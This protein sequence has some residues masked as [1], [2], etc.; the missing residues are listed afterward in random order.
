MTNRF[1]FCLF[2]IAVFFAAE[3]IH[4]QKP[5]AATKAQDRESL[6]RATRTRNKLDTNKNGTFEKQENPKA[7][8]R[9]KHLDANN[10]EVL[11]VEE[12]QQ[13]RRKEQAATFDTGGEQKLNVVYKQT[14]EGDQKLDIYYPASKQ[15]SPYPVIIYTHGGGWAA[16]SK[17]GV[18]KTLFTPLFLKLLD[19]GFVVASVNYRLCKPHRSVRMRDC[20]IDSK[21]AV[22]YLA[23]NSDDLNLDP[24]RMF[25][26]GDSAGGQIAQMLLLTSPDTLPGDPTLADSSYN[27]VAGVSWYG[28]SSFEDMQLFNHDD[29][30]DF[31]DRF[32]K[33]ITGPA[34]EPSE[35]E[36]MALY[37][38]MSTVNYVTDESPPLLMIQGNKDTTI[39]VKHA[40][41]M[42]QKAE[43]VGAPVEIMIIE[44]SGHN[45]RKA[46]ADIEPS[47]DVIV[48]RTV[49]FF[50]D[51]QT[52]N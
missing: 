52:S 42:Q 29:R 32:G 30:P 36:K 17:E 5:D 11:T 51:H 35:D 13:E 45:W 21:D 1:S 10:D 49:Q 33:R 50:V 26:F 3:S 18:K 43:S 34:A 24:E 40:F 19:E 15:T 28:P 38:E 6:V 16:G 47:L 22:R 31:K 14:P 8:N 37:R 12:L 44:N 23:K 39:P 41:L 20:V 9:L 2:A 46:G 25:V 7:W 48:D 27:I 4:A